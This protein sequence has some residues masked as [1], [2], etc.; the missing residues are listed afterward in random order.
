M[1]SPALVLGFLFATLYG[2][3]GHLILGGD[4]RRLAFFLIAGWFG[5]IVGQIAASV[6]NVSVLDIGL[7]HLF[8]ATLGALLSLLIAH[9]LT[10]R[11]PADRF[12]AD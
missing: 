11:T 5:F 7:L 10:N 6:M 2:A 12:V 1:P 8:P 9:L 4:A 3:L